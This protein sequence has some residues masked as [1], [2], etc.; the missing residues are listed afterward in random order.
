MV[1]FINGAVIL[2]LL[3]FFVLLSFED[4]FANINSTKKSLSG[5]ILHS[6]LFLKQLLRK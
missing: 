6:R 2:L 3:L 4:H 1:Y 5:F